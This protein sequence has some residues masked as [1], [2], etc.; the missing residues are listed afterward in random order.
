MGKKCENRGFEL[1]RHQQMGF[2]RNSV[3]IN[4]LYLFRH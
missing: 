4:E 2:R 1:I 3:L